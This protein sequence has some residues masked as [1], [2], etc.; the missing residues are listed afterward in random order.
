M[1]SLGVASK[2]WARTELR[3]EN[4]DKLKSLEAADRK[5]IDS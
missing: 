5:M 1:G 4:N 2:V 3:L